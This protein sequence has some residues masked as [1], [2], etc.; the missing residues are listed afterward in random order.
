MKRDKLICGGSIAL[1]RSRKGVAA[2][3]RGGTSWGGWE[4]NSQRGGRMNLV[5]PNH[6]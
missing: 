6:V 2:V 5:S 3:A 1:F 4:V